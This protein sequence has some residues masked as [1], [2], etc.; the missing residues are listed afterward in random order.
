MKM[1][2]I[3]VLGHGVVGSGVLEVLLS[4][5][6]SIT[7]RAKEAIRVRYVLDLREFPEL[8]YAEVFTKDFDRILQ[9]PEV[10]IVVECMG[11]LEPAFTYAKAC[12]SNGKSFVTSNKELVAAR[13]AELLALAQKNNLNFLFEASVGGGIPIIRPLNSSLPAG[14]QHH[15]DNGNCQRHHQLYS[16]QDDPGAHGLCRRP[17][18]GPAAG[19]C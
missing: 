13:G 19:L 3:A 17:Q 9:D 4:H 8:P 14:E 16:D 10:R 2:D 12:L 6:D 11:G 15:R 7:R 5:G 18:S 1:A